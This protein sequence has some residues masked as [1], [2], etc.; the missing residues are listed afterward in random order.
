MILGTA[1]YMSPEQAKGRAVNQRADI[2]AFGCVLFEMLSGTRAFAG[3]DISDVLVAIIRDEPSWQA[4][5]ASTPAHIQALLR[6]CLQKDLK[7][8]VPHIGVARLDLAEGGAVAETGAEPKQT[9]RRS[10][11]I[12]RL[13]WV[14][15]GAAIAAAAVFPGSRCPLTAA[16][17]FT[18]HH[19]QGRFLNS[20]CVGWISQ[21]AGLS[22]P[23]HPWSGPQT[24]PRNNLSGRLTAS[25][26]RSS[27]NWNASSR[28]ST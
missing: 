24:C 8:R 1:A 20:G 4:L 23:R 7:K 22:P 25:T 15:A 27:T 9:A 26:W 3:E 5:P 28:S 6:R 18:R 10:S 17:L 16:P 2:W 19:Q 14:T 21:T 11:F 12:E 13:A